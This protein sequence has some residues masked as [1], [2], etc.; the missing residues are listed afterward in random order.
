MQIVA[1]R[2]FE[3]LRDVCEAFV[4]HQQTK[5]FQTDR[6]FADMLATV[7][8]RAESFLGIVH[9]ERNKPVEPDH[10]SNRVW[11]IGLLREQRK[12]GGR[13]RLTDSKRK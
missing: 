1:L 3:D 4:V 8:M 10:A 13:F 2:C 6:S 7:H 9:M 5:A 12:V 11:T